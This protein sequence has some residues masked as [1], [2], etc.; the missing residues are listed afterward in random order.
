MFDVFKSKVFFRE[1]IVYGY[2][3]EMM[4]RF[5]KNK[6]AFDE[7]EFRNDMSEFAESI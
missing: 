2:C 3:T 7:Q 1:D 5:G 6:K 4:V